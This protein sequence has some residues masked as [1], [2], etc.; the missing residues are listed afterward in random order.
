MRFERKARRRDDSDMPTANGGFEAAYKSMISEDGVQIVREFRWTA[1]F[2]PAGD[3]GIQMGQKG[4]VIHADDAQA[5]T[6]SVLQLRNSLLKRVE[7]AAP[8]RRCGVIREEQAR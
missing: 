1:M 2:K 8:I 5:C 3:A 6:Q 7:N 4:C